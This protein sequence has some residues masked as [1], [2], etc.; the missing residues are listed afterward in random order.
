MK[1]WLKCILLTL[2]VAAFCVGTGVIASKSRESR[3]VLTCR[4]LSIHFEDSLKFETEGSI[5]EEVNSGYGAFIGQRI[6]DV[7]LDR[8]ESMLK[9]R[10]AIANAEV[11][12]AE[13]CILH[14][15]IRQRLPEIRVMPKGREGFYVDA[16]GAVFPLCEDFEIEVPTIEGNVDTEPEGISDMLR[17]IRE[18]RSLG[19]IGRFSRIEMDRSG[20]LNVR[21][22]GE[23]E[24]FV[25]GNTSDMGSKLSKVEK[26]LDT[27]KGRAEYATVNVKYSN[28]I[29]CSR[30]DI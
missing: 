28:Q 15:S 22:H 23:N 18:C 16:G 7:N 24:T 17:F 25:L 8:I 1:T 3:D 11:W 30:K 10:A 2:F 14:V 26:Y 4:Q 20:N 27:V 21:L 5:R 13:D 6:A 9:E 19:W 29:I 12:M